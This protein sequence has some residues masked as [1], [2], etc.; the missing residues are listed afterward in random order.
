MIGFDSVGDESKLEPHV[1]SSD[2]PPPQD[3]DSADNPPYSYYLYYM[4]SNITQVNKLRRWDRFLCICVGK[5]DNYGS[6]ITV[7]KL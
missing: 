7:F 5:C 3:W 4:Y 6:N 1:F 2:S